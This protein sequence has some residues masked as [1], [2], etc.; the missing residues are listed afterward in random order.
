[1]T[2]TTQKI[3]NKAIYEDIKSNIY[4]IDDI[5]PS[6]LHKAAQE[7]ALHYPL[8]FGHK[9]LGPYQG[10]QFWSEQWGDSAGDD[11]QLA[12]WEFWAIWLVLQENKHLIA[13]TVGNIQ[14][15]QIQL[16]LTTKKHVGGLHVDVMDQAPAYTMVYLLRGDSGLEFWSNN[17][18][19]LN[20]KLAELS[21]ALTKGLATKDEVEAERIKT[22][23]MARKAG[24]L[25]SKDETWYQ[26]GIENHPGELDSYKVHNVP[27]KEGRMVI[28]PSK[29][30][31]QGLPPKEVSPRL[32]LGFIFS[33]EATPFM[34]QRKILHPIFTTE[35]D[36]DAFSNSDLYRKVTNGE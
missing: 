33:G 5:V 15:N 30:I 35:W 14:C 6:W 26:D 12:P 11:P 17:P 20:P 32:S 24:G 29:Y 7:K 28:F 13:P 16:N 3:E 36:S 21:H 8:K 10:Y 2:S 9:G 22:K 4:V 31:H 23:E 18:D 19:H 25:R 34:R 1:M 27:W